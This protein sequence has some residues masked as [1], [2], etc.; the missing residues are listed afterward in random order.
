MIGQSETESIS[1]IIFITLFCGGC[2][3]LLWLLP[4]SANCANML[5]GNN[6]AE[7]MSYLF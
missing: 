7:Q 3:A 5:G 4:T 1:Q 6:F 2:M